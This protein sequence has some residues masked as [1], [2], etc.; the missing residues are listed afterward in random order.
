M[1]A[2]PTG[3]VGRREPE[4]YGQAMLQSV[5]TSWMQPPPHQLEQQLGFCVQTVAMHGSQAGE[6]A[7]PVSHMSCGQ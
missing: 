6:S 4:R 2:P 3:F 5:P 7:G 1:D